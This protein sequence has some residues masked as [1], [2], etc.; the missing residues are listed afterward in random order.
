VIVQATKQAGEMQIE[1]HRD[2]WDGAGLTPATITIKTKQV[3]LRPA[4]G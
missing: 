4:V 1:A 3:E 2:G